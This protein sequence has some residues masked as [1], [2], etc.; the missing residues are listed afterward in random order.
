MESCR[1]FYWALHY[2]EL[3]FALSNKHYSSHYDRLPAVGKSCPADVYKAY[4]RLEQESKKARYME[5]GNFC[6]S[7]RAVDRELRRQKLRA[8]QKF[9]LGEVRTKARLVGHFRPSSFAATKRPIA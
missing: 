3:Y 7:A 4:H 9:V 1:T 8:I 6:M 5:N 2:V